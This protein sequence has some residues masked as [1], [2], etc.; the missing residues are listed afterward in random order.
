MFSFLTSYFASNCISINNSTNRIHRGDMKIPSRG[1]MFTFFM[2]LLWSVF[3]YIFYASIRLP[4][5]T[6]ALV[7]FE[8]CIEQTAEY[9][10]ERKAFGRPLLDNQVIHYRLAEL[11]TEVELL[12]S[13]L[14]R[15]IGKYNFIYGTMYASCTH[16]YTCE[17]AYL[18]STT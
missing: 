1:N 7:P 17:Y 14:Y 2:P 13:L 5:F 9:C 8:R 10:R 18:L 16:F 11:Q 4:C 12:R 6:A 15:A 3:I